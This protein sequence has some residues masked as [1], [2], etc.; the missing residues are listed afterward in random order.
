MRAAPDRSLAL[1]QLSCCGP[2]E[3]P[4]VGPH[5]RDTRAF[6]NYHVAAPLKARLRWCCGGPRRTPLPQL[7]CCGPIEG[8]PNVEGR[9]SDAA[10]FRNYHV[11]APLK[12]AL[13]RYYKN[14]AKYL[15]QLSCC[16]PIEGSRRTKKSKWK[17]ILPQLSCCGPIEGR[18]LPR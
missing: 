7:S 15:P 3:G 13:N 17:L 4:A 14:M 9:D 2:I 6:R 12:E 10:T 1:P 11:A 8:S 18:T 16:G 5:T